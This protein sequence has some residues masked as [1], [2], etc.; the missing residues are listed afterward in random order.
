MALLARVLRDYSK[1]KK[2]VN[3][4]FT[5]QMTRKDNSRVRKNERSQADGPGLAAEKLRHVQ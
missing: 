4:K 3:G 5:V 2:D 1:L